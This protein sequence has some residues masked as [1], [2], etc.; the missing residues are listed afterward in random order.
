MAANGRFRYRGI[1][2]SR[3]LAD[4]FSQAQLR[5]GVLDQS[6][7][8]LRTEELL[9]EPAKLLLDI[10]ETLVRGQDEINELFV[11]DLR[12]IVASHPL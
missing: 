2:R 1:R 3:P 9:L 6:S 12:E 7:F 5:G 10:F 4:A 8:G 11:A